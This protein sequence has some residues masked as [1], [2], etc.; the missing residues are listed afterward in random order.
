VE[1]RYGMNPHQRA[2][3][4][5]PVDPRRQP[6]RVINGD[7]SYLNVLDAVGA[8]QLVS[9]AS[10]ALGRTAA[11]SFKHVSPAGAATA[12]EI[13]AVMADTYRVNADGVG[14]VT[15]AYLRARDADPRS[16]Y[17]D[18]AAVSQPVD[19]ELADLLRRVVSDGIIAPGYEP[20]VVATLSAKQRGRFLVMQADP[21]FRPPPEE[22][23]EVYGV[24]LTQPRDDAPLTRALLAHPE[25]PAAAAD[26]LLLGL[27]VARYTQSNSVAYVRGGMTLGIGAGQ[28][29]RVDCT[30]LAGAKVD[31][32]WLRRHP[33][34]RAL[35]FDSDTTIQDRIN[36]KI[37]AIVEDRDVLEPVERD[38]WLR[39]L[40]GVA[41]VSD[42][43]LPFTD[44][45]EQ[46]RRHGV[47]YI[48][49]PGGSIRSDDV[50]AACHRLGITLIHTGIRLFRH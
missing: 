27:V 26:D 15:S 5:V 3:T 36:A 1:L 11:S 18:F 42:G 16:S 30:Q 34:V 37:T 31:G 14:A 38:R 9:E 33:K 35:A 29:S 47:R 23:R 44:N 10:T 45:V 17:G 41:F 22:V 50:R 21:E 49:E 46:A 8:W 28:Q 25:L 7:A 20:G 13:D 12:G 19:L 2:A 39:H 40:D 43:A 6:F 32:W 48:A 24:R 4:A